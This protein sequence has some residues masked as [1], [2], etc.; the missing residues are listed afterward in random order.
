MPQT[1]FANAESLIIVIAPNENSFTDIHF[2]LSEFA[3]LQNNYSKMR[4]QLR[5]RERMRVT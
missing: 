5:E 3:F 4:V 1:L 2:T